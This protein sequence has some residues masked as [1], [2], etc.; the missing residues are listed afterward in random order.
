MLGKKSSIWIWRG[1]FIVTGVHCLIY[2]K[3]T[4][5]MCVLVT[6]FFPINFKELKEMKASYLGNI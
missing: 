1:H 2:T 5:G 4:S 6:S 3:E